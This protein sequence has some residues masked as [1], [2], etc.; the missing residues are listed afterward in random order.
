MRS[1]VA[2][3]IVATALALAG[4]PGPTFVVQQYTG[5]VRPPE[6]IAILRVNGADAVRLMTLDDETMGVPVAAD[7][8]LHIELL[9]GRHSLTVQNANAPMEVLPPIVF[10]AE[11]NKV[12]R[13]VVAAGA[14][15]KLWEVDRAADTTTR[16]VTTPTF[17]YS[18]APNVIEVPAPAPAQR[19]PFV[20]P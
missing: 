3:A 12:Y 8:R 6:S 19:L 16:E 17:V 9:P 4:C 18:P 20:Q 7:A 1:L 15:A 10:E 14:P 13:V 11:P 2:L 5:P